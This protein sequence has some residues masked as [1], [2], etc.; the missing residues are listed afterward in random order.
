MSCK[1]FPECL[2]NLKWEN[3][4][5]RDVGK[6]N[7]HKSKRKK[8]KQQS[9]QTKQITI[10][11]YPCKEKRKA[12]QCIEF[13]GRR[14]QISCSE[15][16]KKYIL[17]MRNQLMDSICYHIDG[18]VIDKNDDCSRCDYAIFVNDQYEGGQGRAIF[19][20]LKG[21]DTSKAIDQ[22]MQTVKMDTFQIATRAYK[23]LYGR[24]VNT[25][26]APR[27]RSTSK[28]IDVM[29]YFILHEGNIKIHE[30]T[31]IEDYNKMDEC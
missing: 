18:G 1:L 16:G 24:I 26:S 21:S 29:E 27:I 10:T 6:K 8:G 13:A 19:I 2:Q 5:T 31:F 28:F 15:N 11:E 22:I 3:N 30:V 23:K 7:V 20:E 14:S 12:D 25:A 4:P 9:E 17:D